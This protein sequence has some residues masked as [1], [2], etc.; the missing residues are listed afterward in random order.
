[1]RR[2]SEVPSVSLWLLSVILLVGALALAATPTPACC[3]AR[4]ISGKPIVNAD[5][6][7]VLIWDEAT[8]TEHFIRKASFKGEAADFGFVVPSP[9]QPELSESGNEAFPYL[10][11]I[12]EPAHLK[13][14]RSGG[15]VGCGCGLKT[16]SMAKGEAQPAVRV[17]EEKVV[18]G[19]KA[20][21]LEA[22]TSAGLVRWFKEHGY[23]F[24][25]EVEAWAKPYVEAKWKFT[26]LK[27]DKPRDAEGAAQVGTQAL[28]LSFKTDRPLFP[29]REPNPE[30]DAEAVGAKHRLLRIYFVSD[31]RY[32]GELKAAN[33]TGQVAWAGELDAKQRA[34]VLEFLKLPPTTGPAEWWLTE[35]EDDWPYREAP[36]DVY[37]SRDRE[38]TPVRRPPIY[39]Y[40]SAPWPA[41][42]AVYLLAF[43][44]AMPPVFRRIRRRP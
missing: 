31:A 5:Q 1:M 16:A 4:P 18:A 26:A 29:Y 39:E 37:F 15:S 27:I 38:Q 2:K 36:S 11:K 43:A 41:D 44:V 23:A 8:K 6:S 22:D 20:S 21:V 42:G 25:P 30:K 3:P 28:R 17:L 9:S 19:Y 13:A 7:V 32:K 12:T 33:W 10:Q 24:S 14:P 40:S 34:A 35:F